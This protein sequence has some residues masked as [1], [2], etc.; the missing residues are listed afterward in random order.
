[1]FILEEQTPVSTKEFLADYDQAAWLGYISKEPDYVHHGQWSVSRVVATDYSS[2]SDVYLAYNPLVGYAKRKKSNIGKLALLYVDLDLRPCYNPFL[3]E[4]DTEYYKQNAIN[5]MEQEVFGIT[6][7]APNYIVDSGRGLYLIYKIYQNENMTKQEHV[8]AAKRWERVNKYLTDAF[9]DY[10]ADPA[11]STDEARVLR[12]PGSI[13]SHSGTSVKF[14]K[15]SDEI[16]TLYNVERDYMS[17]PTEAQLNKLGQ[18]EELLGITCRVT[19]RRAIRRFM[20]AHEEEYRREYNKKAPSDKQ[21]KY[22]ADIA[23]VLKINCPQFKTAGGASRFIKKYNNDFLSLKAQKKNH[24]T[25]IKDDDE[26]T[27]KMLKLRLKRIE[28]ALLEAPKDSYRERGLFFY[29]LFACEFTGDTKLAADMTLE[30]IR[31]MDNPLSEASAMRTT[32]SAEKYW[33]NNKVYKMTDEALARWF[34][35]SVE[36]W[37]SL[38][39]TEHHAEDKELRKARNARYYQNKLKK[40]GDISKQSKIV[41]RRE[42]ICRL[43]SVGKNKAEICAELNISERTYYS[44]TKAIQEQAVVSEVQDSVVEGTAKKLDD[45]SNTGPVGPKGEPS[46]SVTSLT[47]ASIFENPFDLGRWSVVL[48]PDSSGWSALV[49]VPPGFVVPGDPLPSP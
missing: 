41:K 44:D 28:R 16:Y 22:A 27:L 14:Y 31:S 37:K 29:R 33:S 32:K 47:S 10:C 7:P 49:D 35:M 30:L 25:Y 40:D 1:M 38:V 24:S 48:A 23:R 26:K 34:D 43:I 36:E 4:Y 9:E 42:E 13:N 11:V 6:A 15:Y 3:D 2:K 39:P 5:L 21:L 46:V 20:E 19:T 45:I 18:M 17:A 12:I 8:N